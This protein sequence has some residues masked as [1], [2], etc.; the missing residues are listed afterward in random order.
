ML[1][2]APDG[3]D[4]GGWALFDPNEQLEERRLQDTLS[5][6]STAFGKF[7]IRILSLQ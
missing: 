1:S 4:Y 6:P 3:L 5:I 2:H 7:R